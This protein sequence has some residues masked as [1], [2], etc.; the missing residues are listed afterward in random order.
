[1][2]AL[3]RIG[4]T[5][6]IANFTFLLLLL[7][8]ENR[9]QLPSWLQVAGRMHPMFLHFPIVLLLFYLLTFWL[10]VKEPWIQGLR[11]VATLSAVLT[12]VMGLLLAAEEQRDGS[13]FY[14]HKWG[15]VAIAAIAFLVYYVHPYL[16]RKKHLAKLAT[17]CIAMAIFLTGH[18]GASLTHGENYLLEPMTLNAKQAVPLD[19]A[20]A[21]DHVVLPIFESKCGACHGNANRKGGLVL[22]DTTSVLQGGKTSPLFEAGHPEKSLLVKRILLPVDDKKHMAP[23]SKPQLTDAESALLQAWVKAGAPLSQKIISLPEKDSFRMLAASVLSPSITTGDGAVAYDFPAADDSKVKALNNNYR[24]VAPLGL[25]SPALS[26]RFFGREGYSHKAVEELLAVKD[27]IT[28]LSLAKLPVRDEDLK[29]LLQFRSLERLNLAQ[30]DVTAK[31]IVQLIAL[32]KL[33]EL[34]L[35]GTKLSF[36]AAVALSRM[37]A[38]TSLY[39]WNTLLDSI[40]VADLQKKAKNLYVDIGYRDHGK[41]ILPL[42]PPVAK[43]TPGIYEASTQIELKHPYRGVEIRYTVDGIEP[44]SIR[45]AVYKQPLT[46]QGFTLIKAKAF[47]NGW[48]G[49]KTMKAVYFTNG[50]KPDSVLVAEKNKILA[51]KE[52]LLFDKDI[53]DLNTSSGAWLELKEP[54]TYLFFFK[55]PTALR[56]LCLNTYVRT[57]WDIF[58]AAKV[59]VLGGMEK[60][61]ETRLG[62]WQQPTPQKSEEPSL[63]QAVVNFPPTKLKCLKL[64]VHPLASIPAWRPSKGK[65]SRVYVSEVVLN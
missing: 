35:S 5:F 41:T 6:L 51:G 37:P 29:P 61:R 2:Q 60:G 16:S 19:K 63:E 52:G 43:T 28:D 34:S 62:T 7:F 45:S 20:V 9:M 53:G 10:S 65:P 13:T 49:S 50:I 25:G 40:A 58:P 44:D 46:L 11:L 4:E 27:Q 38:L 17:L 32:K 39:A 55:Q 18:W 48:Y 1:M 54:T 59:E 21:F 33:K 15:G 57:E 31:G 47:K 42:S 36:D 24:V 23:K 12:A 64:V 14:W 56:Q 30:T 3:K 22:L 8:F 26:A